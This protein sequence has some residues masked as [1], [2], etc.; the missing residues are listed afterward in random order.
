MKAQRLYDLVLFAL[1]VLAFLVALPLTITT[2]H[3][4]DWF[5]GGLFALVTIG[6]AMMATESHGPKTDDRGHA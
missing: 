5:G 3:D 1:A 6:A 2:L 4:G